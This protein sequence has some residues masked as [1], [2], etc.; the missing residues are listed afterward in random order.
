VSY[1]GIGAVEGSGLYMYINIC[2]YINIC[3]YIYIYIHM[4]LHMSNISSY[5]I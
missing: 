3:T 4:R 5:I 1:A 2:L